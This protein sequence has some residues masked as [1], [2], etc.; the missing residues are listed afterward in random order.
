[1]EEI[2]KAAYINKE[3]KEDMAELTHGEYIDDDI[4]PEN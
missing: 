3:K 2:E 1:M 4:D